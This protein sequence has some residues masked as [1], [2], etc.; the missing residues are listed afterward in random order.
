MKKYITF[1]VIAGLLL[2]LAVFCF[3]SAQNA[4][5]YLVGKSELRIIGR[6]LFKQDDISSF[7]LSERIFPVWIFSLI[8]MLICII[9]IGVSSFHIWKLSSQNKK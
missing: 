8:V 9:T 2:P 5:D 3:A 1:I 6:I 4:W 7:A